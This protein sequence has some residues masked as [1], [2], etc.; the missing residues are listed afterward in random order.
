MDANCGL[1]VFRNK[2]EKELTDRQ[3]TELLTK[4]K[5]AI[6]IGFK[7]TSGKPFDA[8]LKFNDE[9]QVIFEFL[10]KKTG[11]GKKQ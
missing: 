1:T 11:K 9:F 4:G 8:G 7:S 3:I 2:S 10:D 5:T 6:I